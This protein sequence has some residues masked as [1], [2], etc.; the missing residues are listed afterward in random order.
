MSEISAIFA[1]EILDSRGNPTVEVEVQT[2]SGSGRAAVP[3]GAST[4]EHEAH[5]LR[6]GDKKRY[7]GKGVLKAV[8]NVNQVLG[9]AVIG[10]DA[11]DQ[12][13]DNALVTGDEL[14]ARQSVQ[15]MQRQRQQNAVLE[16]DLESHRRATSELIERV[17]T[18]EAMVSDARSQGITIGYPRVSALPREVCENVS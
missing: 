6:D 4:G 17:N 9:P 12:A 5:E 10:V 1:R 13:A 11:L 2:E 15:Q 7:L 8:S 18:L 14:A 16:A 3:S